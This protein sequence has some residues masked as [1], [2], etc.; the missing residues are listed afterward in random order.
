M[1]MPLIIVK[2]FP[3]LF[4]GILP[5]DHLYRVWDILFYEGINHDYLI[6]FL[7]LMYFRTNLSL[8]SGPDDHYTLQAPSDEHGPCK[9]PP[10][11]SHGIT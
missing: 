8:S 9:N 6:V 3:C 5:A 10:R 7:K 1:K 11:H 4:A 2:R